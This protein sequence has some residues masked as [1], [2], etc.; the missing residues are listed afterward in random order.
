MT[1]GLISAGSV[2][3]VVISAMLISIE[4]G[5][6]IASAYFIFASP[7]SRYIP[8]IISAYVASELFFSAWNLNTFRYISSVI[9]TD[10][11]LFIST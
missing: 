9:T 3:S 5:S 7:H 11:S 4:A 2:S 6:R 8:F 10:I 1:I